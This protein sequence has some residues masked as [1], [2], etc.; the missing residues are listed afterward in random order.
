MEVSSSDHQLREEASSSPAAA[1]STFGAI[2][3][4]VA[5]ATTS[6]L[7]TALG[8]NKKTKPTS[9]AQQGEAASDPSSS[10]LAQ[11]G[12]LI[13]RMTSSKL[14]ARPTAS[15]APESTRSSMRL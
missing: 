1:R 5:N 15:D 10:P 4:V 7:G 13:D 12:G 2:F 3:D 14:Q 11:Q 9:L 8:V 6:L